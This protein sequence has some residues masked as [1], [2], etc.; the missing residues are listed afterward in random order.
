MYC[1]KCSRGNPI[2]IAGGE[3]SDCGDGLGGAADTVSQADRF[4]ETLQ[5]NSRWMNRIVIALIVTVFP[6]GF[7]RGDTSRKR[8]V[9]VGI[10]SYRDAF[11]Q[12]RTHAEADARAVGDL[13]RDQR[14]IGAEDWGVRPD[15]G[16]EKPL[17]RT[18]RFKLLDHLG[19][20][21]IIRPK[22]QPAPPP[23]TF[24]DEQLELAL[25]HLRKQDWRLCGGSARV[26]S[27]RSGSN[28][29]VRYPCER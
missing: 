22:G 29:E 9:I 11:I 25:Q 1:A 27:A 10:G 16:F 24:Q 4:E 28:R 5:M 26:G 15:S 14:Y 8:A 12:P 21:E 7:A 23:S 2:F 18:D 17:T 20:T 3:L 13:V 19:A 6:G